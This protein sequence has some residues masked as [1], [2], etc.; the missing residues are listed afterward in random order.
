MGKERRGHEEE[1]DLR[2]RETSCCTVELG[3]GPRAVRMGR[4][5]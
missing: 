1:G 5:R 3:Q 4:E 2:K